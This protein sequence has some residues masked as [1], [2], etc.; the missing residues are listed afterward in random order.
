M[1]LNKQS[2]IFSIVLLFSVFFTEKVF[3]TDCDVYKNIVGNSFPYKDKLE[4]VNGNC[5]RVSTYV[6]C[7]DQSNIVDV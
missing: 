4:E 6:K 5:C 1:F 3:A 2:F 7:D